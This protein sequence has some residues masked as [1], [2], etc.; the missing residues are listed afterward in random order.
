MWSSPMPSSSTA[1]IMPSETR[2]YFFAAVISKPPGSMAPDD[3]E[4]HPVAGREVDRA[5][6]DAG[7]RLRVGGQLGVAD[8]DPAVADRLLELGQ[9]LDRDHLGGD[10]AVHV[11]AD[12]LDRLD[13]E[14]GQGQAAA[15]LERVVRLGNGRVLPQPGNWNSHRQISIPNALLNRTS[16]S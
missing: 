5:A 10:H 3:G 13:L 4:R 7:Q 12:L 14:A 2:P 16:P 8:G 9:L 1:Q 15:D 11:V 6:D